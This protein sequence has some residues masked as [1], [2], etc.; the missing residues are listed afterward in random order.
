MAGTT[1][2]SGDAVRHADLTGHPRAP[3]WT[4]TGPA[5]L[6]DERRPVRP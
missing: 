6:R 1:P 3:G 2:V 4:V 5:A